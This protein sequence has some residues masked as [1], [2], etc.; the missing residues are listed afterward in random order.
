MT[1]NLVQARPWGAENAPKKIVKDCVKLDDAWFAPEIEEYTLI[2]WAEIMVFW[3]VASG[4]KISRGI[5]KWLPPTELLCPNCHL[6]LSI[7]KY[8][9]LQVVSP[10]NATL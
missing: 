9:N 7:S 2:Y 4:F 3:I 5:C 10:K 8:S 6:L 1:V